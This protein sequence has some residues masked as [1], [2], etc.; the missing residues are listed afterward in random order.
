[1]ARGYWIVRVDVH[2]PESYKDYAQANGVAFAEFGAKFLVRGG[3]FELV[4]GAARERNVVLEFATYEDAVACWH[5][6]TYQ[7]ARAKQRG[8]ESDIVIIAGYDGPQP[9]ESAPPV[10][11]NPA[12][13]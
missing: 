9:N 6:K 11:P 2:D 5:S 12:S 1:M 7:D 8:A 10:P 4:S 13:E 3:P